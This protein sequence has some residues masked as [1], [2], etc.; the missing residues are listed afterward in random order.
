[1][2]IVVM[3]PVGSGKTTQA[4]LLADHLEIPYLNVGDLLFY[5]SQE[6]SPQGKEIREAMQAGKLVDEALTL[7]LVEEHLQG[8]EH[9]AGT[10]IDGFPRNLKQAKEPTVPIDVVFYLRVSDEVTKERL[11]KRG[12]SDDTEEV[13]NKRLEVYHQETEPI[14]E[15][16]KEQG[17]LQE[18]DG[19]KTIPQIFQD[20]EQ[21]LTGRTY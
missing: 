2:N 9:S 21:K 8:K 13:I 12:R 15:Y 20:I 7:R 4:E 10:I 3:G 18:V 16:Y 11:L 17:I 19:E 5:A 14:L 1:M 6:D